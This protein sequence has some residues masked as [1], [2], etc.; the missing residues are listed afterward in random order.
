MRAPRQTG[1]PIGSHGRIYRS[2]S[3]DC[4]DTFGARPRIRLRQLLGFGTSRRQDHCADPDFIAA[5]DED[6][7]T[8]E[9]RR[10][11]AA[12]AVLSGDCS[13]TFGARPRIRSR[14]LLGFGTSRRQDHCADPD[15]IAASDEDATIIEKRRKL[16]RKS[17]SIGVLDGYSLEPAAEVGHARR[18]MCTLRPFD[19]SRE[20]TTDLMTLDIFWDSALFSIRKAAAR[21]S[22]VARTA[23]I[24]EKRKAARKFLNGAS[25]RRHCDAYAA[26]GGITTPSERRTWS[27]PSSTVNAATVR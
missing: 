5:S 13:D 15:F 16:R 14:Q 12:R 20:R 7:T 23:T 27:T 26:P 3:G 19:H 17:S 1:S 6:A 2:L 25:V 24:V 9:K 22:W 8:I 4:I 10:K 21:F 11:P 18:R